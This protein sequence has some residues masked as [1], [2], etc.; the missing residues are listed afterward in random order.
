MTPNPHDPGAPSPWVQRWT[1]LIRPQGTALDIA[2]GG[3]RHLHALKDQ[4]LRVTGVDRSASALQTAAQFGEVVLADIENKPWPLMNGT[5]PRQFDA[6]VVTNYLWRPLFP[7]IEQSLAPGGVLIYETFSQGN[8][9]VGKPS[10]PE[11]LLG[12]G[13]LLRAFANVRVIAFEE[14]FLAQPDRFVQ[15]IAA[16]KVSASTEMAPIPMRYT[17]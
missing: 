13:E 5:Q 1:H 15:C 4:G 17:L 10:R 8:E 16:V 2:C 9:T 12:S 11:F 6:I 7:I 3:G 14:G